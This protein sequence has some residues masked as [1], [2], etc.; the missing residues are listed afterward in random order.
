MVKP[1]YK[2][3]D[4]VI[5]R[6]GAYKQ[7]TVIRII[8]VN[9]KWSGNYPEEGVIGL[10][11]WEYQDLNGQWKNDKNNTGIKHFESLV[12]PGTEAG[13]VLFGK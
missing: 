10:Y 2:V 9:P 11:W 12:Y 1:L 7:A 5:P 3:G 6:P 13:K 8:E 4:I